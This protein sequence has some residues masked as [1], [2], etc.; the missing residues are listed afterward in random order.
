MGAPHIAA[1]APQ[2]YY[3]RWEVFLRGE[4]IGEVLAATERA[5][6]LRATH[7][8]KVSREDRKEL[9]VRPTAAL[10]DSNTAP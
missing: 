2:T 9:Q 3:R 4:Q 1:M 5:A 6:C 10:S 7:R 8:F